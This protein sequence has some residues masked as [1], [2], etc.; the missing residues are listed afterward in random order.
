MCRPS[1]GAVGRSLYEWTAKSISLA[2]S[3]SRSAE[4]KT[5]TPSCCTGARRAVAGGD[6]LDQLDRAGRWRRSARRRPAC[7]WASASA[8]PRVPRRS[9]VL[10]RRPPISRHGVGLAWSCGT[11]QVEQ[12]AQQRGVL[13]AAGLGGELAHPHGRRVQQPLDDPVH[14]V[15]DL[16]ALLVGEVRAA[17]GEPAQ[18]GGD[19]VVGAGAQRG[20]GRRD[21]GAAQPGEER[22][23]LGGD[24]L[25]RPRRSSAAAGP[26][27]QAR[28]PA[29][30]MSIDA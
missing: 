21:V 12:L 28:R 1:A 13:V 3:A 30:S 18:L 20:D 24:D 26:R 2:S 25:P 15:G 5:P 7:D 19:H 16:G 29:A 6:D 8:L 11:S 23:D 4:T 27:A 9:G 14:G 10:T 22:L 17:L